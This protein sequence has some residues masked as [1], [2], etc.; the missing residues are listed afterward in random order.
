MWLDSSHSLQ[1]SRIDLPRPSI[2]GKSELAVVFILYNS[3]MI[4]RF[5]AL[6]ITI[7]LS[8]SAAYISSA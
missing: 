3:S 6:A 1:N 4:I 8:S 7:F 2:P 5:N